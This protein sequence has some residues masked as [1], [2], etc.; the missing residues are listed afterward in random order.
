MGGIIIE[1]LPKS[2]GT[3]VQAGIVVRD[4]RHYRFFA[5]TEAFYSLEGRLF[6]NPRAAEHAALCRVADV[7]APKAASSRY[8]F[9]SD[10]S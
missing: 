3:T 8:P 10:R 2:D 9:A 6:K 5:A 7:A 4:G 1:I